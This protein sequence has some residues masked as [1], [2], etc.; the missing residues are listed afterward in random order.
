MAFTFPDPPSNLRFKE[1]TTTKTTSAMTTQVLPLERLLLLFPLTSSFFPSLE[2]FASTPGELDKILRLGNSA[3]SWAGVDIRSAGH[4]WIQLNLLNK[5]S[6]RT[7]LQSFHCLL[8]LQFSNTARLIGCILVKSKCWENYL[9]SDSE[10]NDTGSKAESVL[11]KMV[12]T[13]FVGPFRN[14]F[15]WLK[16]TLLSKVYSGH[17]RPHNNRKWGEES[18]SKI[19][20]I[21]HISH[22]LGHRFHLGKVDTSDS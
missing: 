21:S 1:T 18:S 17:L 8:R 15:E 5:L 13:F 3:G 14:S 19:C 20:K 6:F 11:K 4:Q 7:P 2:N 9:S 16:V 22:Y 10:R 12:L